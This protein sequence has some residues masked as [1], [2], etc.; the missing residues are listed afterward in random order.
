ME[1]L[2]KKYYVHIIITNYCLYILDS[3]MTSKKSCFDHSKKNS[4]SE[5][6][7]PLVRYMSTKVH[8]LDSGGCLEKHGAIVV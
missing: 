2:L 4:L 7:S 3:V 6:T 5:N 1:K 8:T